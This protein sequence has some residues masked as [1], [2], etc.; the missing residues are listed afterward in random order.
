MLK[1]NVPSEKM[2]PSTSIYGSPPKHVEPATLCMSQDDYLA[3]DRSLLLGGL[4]GGDVLGVEN[5]E[6]EGQ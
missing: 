6:A 5:P 2:K 3:R 1:N 4:A